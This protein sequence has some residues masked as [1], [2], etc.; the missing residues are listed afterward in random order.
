MKDR[1]S[2]DDKLKAICK[3]ATRS[4]ENLSE[5]NDSSVCPPQKMRASGGGRKKNVPEVREALF[6]Y[7]VN[8]RESMKGRLPKRILRQKTKQL[9]SE[10]L[11]ENPLAEGEKPLKFGWIQMWEQEYN[12]SLR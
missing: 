8:V 7:F 1:K 9:Y 11:C 4:F 2:N 5:L 12:I 6:S 3:F 10:Q